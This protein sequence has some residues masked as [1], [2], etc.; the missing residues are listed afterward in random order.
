M[1]RAVLFLVQCKTLRGNALPASETVFPV[2]NSTEKGPGFCGPLK[3]LSSTL[4]GIETCGTESVSLGTLEL[5]GVYAPFLKD[6]FTSCSIF[7]PG[8]AAG[9]RVVFPMF[10]FLLLCYLFAV[11]V[12]WCLIT[13][14]AFLVSRFLRCWYSIV[15]SFPPPIVLD[16]WDS[17]PSGTIR[18]FIFN[19]FLRL[20]VSWW[21]FDRFFSYLAISYHGLP[22][23][24]MIFW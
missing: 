5:L 4:F 8:T 13:I 20:D 11:R 6:T 22:Q 17:P 24:S 18:F 16:P 9:I 15:R 10:V 23:L 19:S 14:Q 1:C 12:A 21:T 7:D 3:H 2:N